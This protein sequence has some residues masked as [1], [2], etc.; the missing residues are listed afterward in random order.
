MRR[1]HTNKTA[2]AVGA[3]MGL[4][5][6]AWALLVAL[7]WAKPLMDFILDLHFLRFDYAMA[8]FALGKA[9]GL[10]ALTAAIGYA[11]GFVFALVWNR[12]AGPHAE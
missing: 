12:L 8:P 3:V 9:A 2:L 6:L 1:I 4:F 10:V 7:G 5:H 11:L